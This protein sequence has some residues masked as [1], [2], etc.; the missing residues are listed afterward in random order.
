MANEKTTRLA[1]MKANISL[2]GLNVA[3]LMDSGTTAS[4]LTTTEGTFNATSESS[5]YYNVTEPI[6]FVLNAT[7]SLVMDTTSY[8]PSSSTTT[9]E[10]YPATTISTTPP[11]FQVLVECPTTTTTTLPPPPPDEE[12]VY[13]DAEDDDPPGRYKR[14]GTAFNRTTPKSLTRLLDSLNSILR[15]IQQRNSSL[16]N[17]LTAGPTT[18]TTSATTTTTTES[19]PLILDEDEK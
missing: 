5:P 17:R 7:E 1:V 2:Q 15:G 4:L 13:E 18:K 16:T 10:S 9:T 12:Y 11:C 3:D 8:G 19:E 6:L 14:Q